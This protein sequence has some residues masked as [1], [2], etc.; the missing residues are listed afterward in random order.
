MDMVRVTIPR[1][2]LS[3]PRFVVLALNPTEFLFYRSIDEDPFDFGLLGCCSDESDISIAP[4]FTIDVFA[5]RGN[6]IESRNVIALLL[7]QY[8]VRHWHEPDI[9]I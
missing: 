4:I 9:D 6:Q 2:H 3:H 8:M 5:I 7:A 1:T